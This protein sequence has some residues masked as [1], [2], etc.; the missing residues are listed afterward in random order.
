MSREP[1]NAPP[2]RWLDGRARVPGADEFDATDLRV[3]ALLR[4]VPP[5]APFTAARS[6]RVAARLRGRE[7]VARL[8]PRWGRQT[9][10]RWAVVV[11][12]IAGTSGLVF[13]HRQL[14]A[15][16]TQ[17]RTWRSGPTATATEVLAAP[18]AVAPPA[19]AL[20]P[21]VA[22]VPAPPPAPVRSARGGLG[23]ATP[24]RRDLA[25]RARRS[26]A[27]ASAVELHT[28]D[29]ESVPRAMKGPAPALL[30]EPDRVPLSSVLSEIEAR[31]AQAAPRAGLG[32]EA[33]LLREIIATF[34]HDEDPRGALALLDEYDRRYPTG[35]LRRDAELIRLDVWVAVGAHARARALLEGM[36]VAASPRAN[37]LQTLRGEL[38]ARTDCAGALADFAAVLARDPG[39]TLAARAERGRALCIRGGR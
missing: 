4:R 35:I 6:E 7:R 18:S 24:R 30:P 8:R 23:P 26:A 12:L 28:P 27:A 9:R 5:P 16:Y 38:R 11:A 37:E 31:P 17:L 29:A 25:A 19:V 3:A 2:Q 21:P 20:P 36:D 14:R 13:A 32:D 34:R 22:A 1:T 15:L 39:A 33:A 10:L